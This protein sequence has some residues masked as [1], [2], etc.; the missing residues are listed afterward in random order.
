MTLLA[1]DPGET[2]GWCL[3][4]TGVDYKG[5][6]NIERYGQLSAGINP[7]MKPDEVYAR[8]TK[9]AKQ[10]MYSVECRKT[11]PFPIEHI[12]IE[13]FTFRGAH[14]IVKTDIITIKMVGMLLYAAGLTGVSYSTQTAGDAKGVITDIRLKRWG[15]WL[16][17]K[18]RHARDAIRHALLY[19]RKNR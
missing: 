6:V 11:L 3:R 17:H 4:R 5:M 8:L 7:N 2:T 19:E 15:Y 10:I 18:E 16:P 9:V 12:V 13:D 1:I 14:R